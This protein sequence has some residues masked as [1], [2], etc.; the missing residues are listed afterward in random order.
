MSAICGAWVQRGD[1][2]AAE[3]CR[4]MLNALAAH[5]ADAAQCIGPAPE[6]SFGHR[7]LRTTPEDAFEAQPLQ[8]SGRL[9][10]VADARIDN[11]E[12]LAQQ[13][14]IATRD[15][16]TLPDSEMLLKAWLKWGPDCLDHLCGAFAFAVW[17]PGERRVFLARDHSGQRPLYF[18]H[19]GGT[20]LFATSARALRACPGVSSE[21]DEAQL[22]NDLIGLA[23][24]YPRTRF[25]ELSEIAPGHCL[26]VTTN[27]ATHRRYW[28]I[29][30]LPETRFPRDSDYAERFREILDGAVGAMLRSTGGIGSEL[31]AGLDSGS[32]TATAAH[33]L[34]ASGR[35]LTAYTAVPCPEF[36]GPVP[37]GY[38]GNEGPAAAEVAAVHPNIRHIL[39][40]PTGSDMLRE[41]AR[42]FPVLDL[43]HAAGL[44]S[45]WSNLI[46]DRAQAAGIKVILSGA[47]GNF[48]ASY[49]GSDL[50][51]SQFRRGQLLKTLRAT[52]TL[53]RLGI[54]SG[55]NA[56]SLTAFALLPWPLRRRLDPLVRSTDIGWSALR[57]TMAAQYGAADKFR[58]S[59]FV[60][61][62]LLPRLMETNF[63]RNQYG[64]YNAAA[65]AGW[66]IDVR[67]PTA[68]RRLFE[69][70]ASIPHEQ[71]ITGGM[72]RSL[73]RRAMR[74]R[75]PEQTLQRR[76]KGLQAADWY[77]SLSRIRT[78]LIEEVERIAV[79]PTA[80]HLLDIERLRGA[81][82][83]WPPSAL[84][85]SR[86]PALYQSTIPRGIA[87]GY[88]IRRIESEIS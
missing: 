32:V 39:V 85:A 33:I 69:F 87:V 19:T 25:R 10:L 8:I 64:D 48:A 84:D 22:V 46:Y 5:G 45:V 15:L 63:Q 16:A 35:D 54:S 27:S 79:S 62:S 14:G 51:Y 58:R 53:R 57:P 21:F 47:L 75:L 66:G 50:L 80:R 38:I 88:F 56:A 74:G 24:E 20:L 76:E 61:H 82:A 60:H 29:H 9:T 3:L 23:P 86:N 37:A 4:I 77:E 31:S 7:L 1:E 43:P 26:L 81:L 40:D 70:C 73:I 67:D 83:A 12:E 42:T 30:H 6:I 52:W 17:E 36:D 2:N 28:D 41:L 72:A 44:N 68:D 13:L 18:R 11:R 59:L 71:Y 65:S 78:S 34:N 55:R 49:S